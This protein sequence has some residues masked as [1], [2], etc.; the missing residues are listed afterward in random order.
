MLADFRPPSSEDSTTVPYTFTLSVQEAIESK[1]TDMFTTLETFTDAGR[2]SP[3]LG[4]QTPRHTHRLTQEDSE[5]SSEIWNL[6]LS[7]DGSEDEIQL[8]LAHMCRDC[9]RFLRLSRCYQHILR[10]WA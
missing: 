10:P 1:S 5:C 9:L 7:T 3:T 4:T 6:Q 2:P 8:H